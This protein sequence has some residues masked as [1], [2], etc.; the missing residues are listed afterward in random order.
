MTVITGRRRIGKTS[1]A[2]EAVKDEKPTVYLFA[3]RKSEASICEEFIPIINN[4][5]NLSIPLE[6]KSFRLVFQLVMEAGQTRPFN[7]IIDEF[8]ELEY[9]NKAVF[10]EIQNLWDQ[11]QHKTNINLIFMGSVYSMMHKIFEG[12]KEPLFGRADNIIRLS[13]FGT[14]TL[15]EIISDYRPHYTNDELLALYS[16][17]GGVPKYVDLLCE[18]T[19]L[20]I[21]GILDYIVRE[22]S[23]FIEEGRNILIEEFGKEYGTYFSILSCISSGI[24]VQSEIEASLGGISIGGQLARLIEDYSLIKRVKPI[25]SKPNT[26]NI[27]YEIEDNFFKFWFRYFDRNQTL[28]AIK[29]YTLLREIIEKDYTTYSGIMLERYFRLKMMESHEYSDIG[30]WWQRKKNKEANEIDIIGL[31]ANKKV[32]VVAEV[33]RQK[34]NYDHKEFIRKTEYLKT[35]VLSGYEIIPRLL[36]LEDM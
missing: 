36:T 23:P 32:A 9:V 10:S 17:T 14:E 26:K 22:T 5:L 16:I 21:P 29:N 35:S 24:N 3:S 25:F 12:Y 18:Y 7:L 11:Y 34:R 33:K 13:G 8:Q 30:S 27:R 15:K 31:L 4:Q 6:I 19:D 28:I 20:S 1:L 2:I